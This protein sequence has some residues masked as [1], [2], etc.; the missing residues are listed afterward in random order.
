MGVENPF[1]GGHV[2]HSIALAVLV[3]L[4]GCGGEAREAA[5]QAAADSV[6]RARAS[7]PPLL[8]P[9]LMNDT[10]PDLYRAR[11]LV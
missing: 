10:S 3:A 6:A 1:A 2:R 11:Q 8:N 9:R 5:E 4:V 7:V